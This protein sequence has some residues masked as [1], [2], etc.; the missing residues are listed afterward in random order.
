MTVSHSGSMKLFAV[1]SLQSLLKNIQQHSALGHDTKTVETCHHHTSNKGASTKGSKWHSAYLLHASIIMS[2]WMNHCQT[3]FTTPS[4]G[5]ANQF[6]FKPMVSTSSA[7][8]SKLTH[9]TKCSN[10]TRMCYAC[11]LIFQMRLTSSNVSHKLLI[12]M[13]SACHSI[14]TVVTLITSY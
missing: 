7:L 4:Q 10:R 2:I 13:R 14:L 11:A 1:T 5:P 6:A 12:D 3:I 8:V 9:I